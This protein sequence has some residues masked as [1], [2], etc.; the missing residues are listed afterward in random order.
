MFL[1]EMLSILTINTDLPVE[2]VDYNTH[3]VF[4]MGEIN[5]L[6][7]RYNSLIVEE[8][9]IG[10]DAVY[11]FVRDKNE[12]EILED[13]LWSNVQKIADSVNKLHGGVY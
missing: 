1:D 4:W 11:F 3:E 10:Y 6:P 9:K 5:Y 7:I 2:V 8:M 12:A 13:E